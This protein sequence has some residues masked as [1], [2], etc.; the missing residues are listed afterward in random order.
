MPFLF[1]IDSSPEA[2]ASGAPA[3]LVIANSIN[4]DILNH[5]SQ[6]F[7][8]EDIFVV[9]CSPQAVFKVRPASRCSSTLSGM[10][11]SALGCTIQPILP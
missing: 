1:H 2:I 9:H 8:L 5:P 4:Q 11:S 6:A 10:L 7:S 3:R